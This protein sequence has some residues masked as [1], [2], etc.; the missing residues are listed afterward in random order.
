MVWVHMAFIGQGDSDGYSF[1]NKTD[2]FKLRRKTVFNDLTQKEF[3]E[4]VN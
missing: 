1:P 4:F 3:I 2:K